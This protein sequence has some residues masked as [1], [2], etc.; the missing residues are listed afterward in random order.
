MKTVM[1]RT[2]LIGK[3]IE[4]PI[5]V[6]LLIFL[7]KYTH[8]RILLSFFTFLSCLLVADWLTNWLIKAFKARKAKRKVVK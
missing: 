6:S 1:D 4:T 5:V 7:G 2:L 3:L 8:D